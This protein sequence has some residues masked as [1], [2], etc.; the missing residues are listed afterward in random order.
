[1]G[2][3]AQLGRHG[4]L[5]P[6]NVSCFVKPPQN[7]DLVLKGQSFEALA[8]MGCVNIEYRCKKRDIDLESLSKKVSRVSVVQVLRRNLKYKYEMNRMSQVYQLSGDS[9]SDDDSVVRQSVEGVEDI[10]GITGVKAELAE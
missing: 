5:S 6:S 9:S 3:S 8:G 2:V 4:I 10:K 1:M 7:L